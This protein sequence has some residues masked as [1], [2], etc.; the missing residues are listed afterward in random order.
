MRLKMAAVL[1]VL[2]M[3]MLGRASQASVTTVILNDTNSGDNFL[4]NNSPDS[5]FAG[6]GLFYY[7]ERTASLHGARPLIQFELPTVPVGM[8][9]TSAQLKLKV[10]QYTYIDVNDG[11]AAVPH[12]FAIHQ[13]LS[14]WSETTSSWNEASTGV[15]WSSP[16]MSAGAD[17]NAAA[18]DTV[19]ITKTDEG[20]YVAW[21][22]TS[23]YL[24]WLAG[25]QANHGL[26][27]IGPAGNPLLDANG[28]DTT[29]GVLRFYNSEYA[30]DSVRPLLTLNYAA[31]PEPASA[32][33]LISGGLLL[34][35]GRRKK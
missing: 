15:D 19:T 18:L 4:F 28:G 2:L 24:D 6:S 30:N 26:T 17:Y 27:I 7:D 13:V 35:A 9:V 22:I 14:P 16:G 31:V 32:I 3:A 23:L 10:Q 5:N 34:A 1:A 20:A 33:L 11:S 8:S 12:D 25:S 21:D 29:D